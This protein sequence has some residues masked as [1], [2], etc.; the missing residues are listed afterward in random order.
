MKFVIV[1]HKWF[2]STLSWKHK[3][4]DAKNLKEAN[5]QASI[6]FRSCTGSDD[7]YHYDFYVIPLEEYKPVKVKLTLKERVMG[8]LKLRIGV[9]IDNE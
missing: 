6:D 4:I 1:F 8:V 9:H 7:F 3:I 5:D 2:H